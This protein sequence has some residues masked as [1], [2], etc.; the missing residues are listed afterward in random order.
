MSGSENTASTARTLLPIAFFVRTTCAPSVL[1]APFSS[2]ESARLAVGRHTGPMARPAS[3]LP[4]AQ[5]V[6]PV[7]PFHRARD[8]LRATLSQT[9]SVRLATRHLS[10]ETASRAHR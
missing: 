2:L 7:N 6:N 10:A 4:T 3:R 8:V 5:K 9:V 1:R